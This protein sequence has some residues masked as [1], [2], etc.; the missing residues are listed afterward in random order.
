MPFARNRQSAAQREVGKALSRSNYRNE[1]LWGSSRS[2]GEVR[3]QRSSV[4]NW[5][6]HSTADLVLGI[7]LGPKLGTTLQSAAEFATGM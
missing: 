6:S 5:I 2:R 7:F 3:E 4:V 1:G